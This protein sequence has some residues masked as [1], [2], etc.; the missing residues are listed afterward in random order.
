MRN[1]N[2]ADD[3][4]FTSG[5]KV[6]AFK[7]CV[8]NLGNSEYHALKS[9][10]SSSD[11]KYMAKT[12]PM[13][14]QYKYFGAGKNEQVRITEDMTLGSLVHC[15]LLT[16]HEFEKEF[17][18][19]PE[20]NLRTNAGKEMK[21]KLLA[22]NVGKM[23]IT[24]ELLEKAKAMVDS[25]M[26]HPKVKQLVEP[27]KKELAFFWTCPFSNL[28]FRAK[29]DGASSKHFIEVKTTSDAGPDYFSKHLFDM[30]WDLSLVH[31]REGVKQVMG[32]EPPA[33]FIVIEREPPFTVQPYIAGPAVWETGHHKW[34]AA[35]TQLAAGIQSGDWPGYY[36]KEFDIP[37]VNPPAWAV[38]KTIPKGDFNGV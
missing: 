31:Y 9:Y 7:G 29:L 14:F 21:E 37:E 12:S 17:F 24:E 23:P 3:V 33:Y 38:N 35:V 18:L 5:A 16:P 10:W 2:R 19:I 27:V 32:V 36:P 6:G 1:I 28:N 34:L 20:L 22:E 4:A 25:A 15:L 13:H 11:L 30:H 8:E 26:S